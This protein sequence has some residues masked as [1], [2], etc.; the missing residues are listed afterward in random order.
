MGNVGWAGRVHARLARFATRVID[1]AAYNG[2]NMRAEVAQ[3]L[4]NKMPEAKV[5]EVGCG[6]GTL[7]RELATRNFASI[8]ALD[9]SVE[10][11]EE[12][13]DIKNVD[14]VCK[15][16]VDIEPKSTDVAIASMVLHELPPCAHVELVEAMLKAIGNKGQVWLIDIHPSYRPKPIM[17]VGEP[18][19]SEY[20]STIQDT[21][22]DV[23]KRNEVSF[24]YDDL[25]EDHVRVWRM[26][27]TNRLGTLR[28][29]DVS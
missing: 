22:A 29:N 11:L 1:K 17:E 28:G 19:I 4:A 20:L 8:L 3:A 2:R 10:M 5:T 9:T 25:I 21:L 16:G 7:T 6:S 27:S 23:A 18:Y 15:N 14:F 26:S 13:R 12:T 24:T